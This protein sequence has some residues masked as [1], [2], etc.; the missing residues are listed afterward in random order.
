MVNYAQTAKL[1]CW[2]MY[3][4]SIEVRSIMSD[5][6]TNL[7][8]DN[9]ANLTIIVRNTAPKREQLYPFTWLLYSGGLAIRL[10][11]AHDLASRPYI[12]DRCAA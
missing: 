12:E 10:H 6:I 5:N 9:R 3:E 1:R 8:N 11:V 7:V 2:Y 4:R